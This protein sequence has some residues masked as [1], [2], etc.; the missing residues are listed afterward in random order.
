MV[1]AVSSFARSFLGSAAAQPQQPGGED[2]ADLTE[3]RREVGVQRL[4]HRD[5]SSSCPSFTGRAPNPSQHPR[6][7]AVFRRASGANIA[8]MSFRRFC[9]VLSSGTLR[10]CSPNQACTCRIIAAFDSGTP[11][12]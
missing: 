3:V 1:S 10:P 6:G 9:S 7:Y 5:P 2:A 12:K 4:G 11:S 8:Q